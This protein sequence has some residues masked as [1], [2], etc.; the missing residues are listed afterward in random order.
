MSCECETDQAVLVP[1]KVSSEAMVLSPSGIDLREV[2]TSTARSSSLKLLN[3]RQD[4]RGSTG[5]QLF[6]FCFSRNVSGSRSWSLRNDRSVD[7]RD[8]LIVLTDRVRV[9]ERKKKPRNG[10]L[11]FH[12]ENNARNFRYDSQSDATFLSFT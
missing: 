10:G 7:G 1:S 8:V 5:L 9:N 3:G 12:K 2:F 11:L 6:P 4:V